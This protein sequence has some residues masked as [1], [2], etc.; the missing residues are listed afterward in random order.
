MPKTKVKKETKKVVKKTEVEKLQEKMAS[1]SKPLT[2]PEVS[3]AIRKSQ[4][5]AFKPLA[6]LIKTGIVSV[7]LTKTK[8]VIKK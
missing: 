8:K 3:K 7:S 2:L 5:D 1:F 6:K 4:T